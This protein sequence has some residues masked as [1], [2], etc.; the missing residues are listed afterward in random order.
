MVFPENIRKHGL[1]LYI[2]VDFIIYL[3]ISFIVL[4]IFNH[5]HLLKRGKYFK[6]KKDF[7]TSTQ[8]VRVGWNFNKILQSLRYNTR[9]YYFDFTKICVCYRK[10]YEM[11]C[12]RR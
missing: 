10:N 1:R 6:V 7:D 2:E 11:R 8:P 12:L 5:F 9:N 3:L 4:I